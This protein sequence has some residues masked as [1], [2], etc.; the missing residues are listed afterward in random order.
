MTIASLRSRNLKGH[1]IKTLIITTTV[2]LKKRFDLGGGWHGGTGIKYV[3][4]EL[5]PP[6]H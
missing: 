5:I 4:L 3:L 6:V 2:A 1:G